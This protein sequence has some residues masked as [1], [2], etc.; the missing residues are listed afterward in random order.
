MGKRSY[1]E[2]VKHYEQC[3]AEH[4]DTHSGVGWPKEE[5]VYKRF[6][7]M[8]GVIRKE[9]KGNIT[10]LDFGCGTSHLYDYILKNNFK[11]IIY[12]GLDISPKFIEVARQKYPK[13]NFYTQDVLEG[14]LSFS[15][16]DYVVMNGVFTQKRGLSFDEMFSYF[17]ETIQK[18]FQKTNRG[19]AFN[20]MAKQ[21]DWENEGNFYLSF[22]VLADF[23][24]KNVSKNFV[25][26]KD[27]GLYEYTTYVYK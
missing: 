10:L 12:S 11:N 21:V 2:I 8:L 24:T 7:V 23:L 5:E 4:G 25:F 3:L 15:N 14:N 6:D 9:D 17:K 19:L 20:V 26:R 13:I 22:D 27:Y 18:V 1:L 16:F